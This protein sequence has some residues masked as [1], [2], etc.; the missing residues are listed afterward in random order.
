MFSVKPRDF[1]DVGQIPVDQQ[2]VKH[3]D[4]HLVVTS[5]FLLP[6]F[7]VYFELWQVVL[8][9]SNVPTRIKLMYLLSIIVG[10][11]YIHK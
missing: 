4:Q 6:H 10:D 11:L 9:L 1:S 5:V 7:D 3:S 2:F 8:T